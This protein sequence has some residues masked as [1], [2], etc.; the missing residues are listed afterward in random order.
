MAHS[1]TNPNYTPDLNLDHVCLNGTLPE[2][3]RPGIVRAV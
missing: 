2:G 3:L 1:P